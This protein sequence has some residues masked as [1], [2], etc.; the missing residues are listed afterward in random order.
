MSG[1]ILCVIANVA[2]GFCTTKIPFNICRA[3]A[4]VGV[5]GSCESL[6]AFTISPAADHGAVPNAIAILGKTYGSSR[7]RAIVF[8]ILGA[9]APAGFVVGGLIGGFFTE[10]ADTRWIWWFTQVHSLHHCS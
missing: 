6:A 3:L 2:S 8:S 9:L 5:A 7:T 4:G 1:T 10:E